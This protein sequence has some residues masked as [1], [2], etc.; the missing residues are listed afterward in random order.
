MD[1]RLTNVE[2]EKQNAINQSNSVY[3]GLLNDN[4]NLYNQ[5]M[6]YANQYETTQ[7]NVLDKQLAY[8]TKLIEQQKDIARENA[9]V[10]QNKAKNDYM[11]YIN[12]YGKQAESLASGGLLNSGVSETAKLGSYNA[13]QNRLSNANKVMQDAI[14]QYD[15]DI[16]QARLN[17]DVAKAQNALKKLE[18][19]LNAAEAFYNTKSTLSQNQLSNTQ[20]LGSDYFNRYQTEYQNIQNEAA[21]KEAIRQYNENMAYQKE[22]DKV[23]DKQWQKEFDENVRQYNQN[24]NLSK[25]KSS[26]GSGGSKSSYVSLNGV[27]GTNP[28]NNRNYNI[29]ETDENGWKKTD[30]KQKVKNGYADVYESPE[31][32]LLFWNPDVNEWNSYGAEAISQDTK[33]NMVG[34]DSYGNVT[35]YSTN[36]DRGYK[37]LRTDE[38]GWGLTNLKQKVKDASGKY[39]DIEVYQDPNGSLW[40]WNSAK[41]D[42]QSYSN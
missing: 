24:Y 6:N 9:R 42:W 14:T 20:Q 32:E 37:I 7:N 38:N 29:L 10:E 25:S 17:N 39:S 21:A 23:A 1:E 33:G 35:T 28:A 22:R 36:G 18:L 31:G 30:M 8:N 12:P 41:Q 13:Y 11:S 40:F 19:Q 3:S 5:N 16:N 4:Q 2:K 26:G 34:T 27:T 15:N